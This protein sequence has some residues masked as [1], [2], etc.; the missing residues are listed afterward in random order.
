M[1]V[2]I[3]TDCLKMPL[4]EILPL[5]ADAGFKELIWCYLW[6]SDELYSA[7]DLRTF[8]NLLKKNDLNIT[9]VHG[10][11]GVENAI[12]SSDPARRDAGVKLVRNRLHFMDTLGIDGALTLH[13]PFFNS[14]QNRTD[15]QIMAERLKMTRLS[16]DELMPDLQKYRIPLA[17]ENM[18]HDNYDILEMLM[19][20]YPAEFVGLTFDTGHGN[21]AGNVE[22]FCRMSSRVMAL[23]LNDN[24]STADQHQL[25]GDGSV[26]WDKCMEQ[27]KKMPQCAGKLEFE[28]SLR[29]PEQLPEAWQRC[30]AFAEKF[31]ALS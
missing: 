27:L 28:L 19:D 8:R 2:A 18:P 30:S 1:R 6:N 16:L 7:G 31:T 11:C 9:N 25:P 12:H 14:L 13:V 23:H 22:N 29:S 3:N 10:S 17:L 5:I 4:A 21:I 26:N 15:R 20:E 24:D